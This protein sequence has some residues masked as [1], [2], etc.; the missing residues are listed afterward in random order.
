MKR[1]TWIIA[2]MLMCATAWAA[3]SL[4]PELIMMHINPI[5]T[6]ES[7]GDELYI[8]IAE[9]P[10]SG[11][12]SHY[13]IPK[14]PLHWPSRHVKKLKEIS[15][16]HKTI[17]PEQAVTLVISLLEQDTP[18]WNTDDLIGTVRVRIKNVN[19]KLEYSWSIPNRA[20]SPISVKSR[21]G[22]AQKF[23]LLGDGGNYEL[24]LRLSDYKPEK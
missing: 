20:D 14:H 21:F 11:K 15:L 7:S 8:D 9:Y 16:W 19:G 6:L 1:V 17:E 13:R 2:L 10:S 24:F 12:A 22:T 4:T 5:K 3:K 23:E 18:P